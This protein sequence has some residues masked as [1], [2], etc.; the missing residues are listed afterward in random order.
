MEIKNPTEIH[1]ILEYSK[2]PTKNIFAKKQILFEDG[3]PGKEVSPEK[4]LSQRGKAKRADTGSKAPA[5]KHEIKKRKT[6][7]TLRTGPTTKNEPF[8]QA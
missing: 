2:L 4:G 7:D 8:F 6:R 3:Q 1:L 5:T